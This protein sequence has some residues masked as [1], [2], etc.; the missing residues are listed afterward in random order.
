[1]GEVIERAVRDHEKRS[2]I[3]VARD[4]RE[5]PLDAP[6]AVKIGLFRA[7]QETL[8]N[9]T[10]HGKG[11]AVTVAVWS[12]ADNLHLEVSDRGPGFASTRPRS[13]GGLGLPG[14]RERTALVGGTF[15]VVS[16]P[17]QGAR[18]RLT[19]P[20]AEVTGAAGPEI[21]DGSAA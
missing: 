12:E 19:W 7:L 2:G 14:L 6:L 8:S 9:A 21:P 15:E 13:G 20:L 17:G 18:I 1:V 5:L 16:S 11:I 4:I 10:R 3:Q